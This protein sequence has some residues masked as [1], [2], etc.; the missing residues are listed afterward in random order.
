[1]TPCPFCG[2]HN[3]HPHTEGESRRYMC[4][5]CDARGPVAFSDDI[6]HRRWERRAPDV[7]SLRDA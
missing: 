4:G 5:T 1:V 6:A 2:D 7:E 3:V